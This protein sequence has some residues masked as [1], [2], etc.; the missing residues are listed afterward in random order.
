VVHTVA[1]TVLER[2]KQQYEDEFASKTKCVCVKVAVRP[3]KLI[4][5]NIRV[6]QRSFVPELRSKSATAVGNAS[7]HTIK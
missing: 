1:T 3:I 4:H 5:I 6:L 2:V 7:Y